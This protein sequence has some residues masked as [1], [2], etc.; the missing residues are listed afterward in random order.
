MAN[1]ELMNEFLLSMSHNMWLENV[2]P[3]IPKPNAKKDIAPT[4]S[5][6]DQIQTSNSLKDNPKIVNVDPYVL[7][8]SHP[9][10]RFLVPDCKF[11]LAYGNVFNKDVENP[12]EG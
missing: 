2:T 1:T 3:T 4:S 5:S 7:F 10:V 11:C 12:T 8:H 9:P 6:K